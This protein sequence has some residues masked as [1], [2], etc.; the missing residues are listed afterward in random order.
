[1]QMKF[2]QPYPREMRHIDVE[3]AD[4]LQQWRELQNF[5]ADYLAENLDDYP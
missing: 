4:H 1:M 3:T 2:P 5:H